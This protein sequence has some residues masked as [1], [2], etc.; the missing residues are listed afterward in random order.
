MVFF[1]GV[2]IS[3]HGVSYRELGHSSRELGHSSQRR[4]MEVMLKRQ[5]RIL[6]NIAVLGRCMGLSISAQL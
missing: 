6:I 1:L 2:G 5:E 4:Q 3:N